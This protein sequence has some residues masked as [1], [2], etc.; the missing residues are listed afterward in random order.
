MAAGA[1]CVG[2]TIRLF[3]DEVSG[4]VYCTQTRSVYYGNKQYLRLLIICLIINTSITEA[5]QSVTGLY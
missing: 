3:S 2:D 5:S 1:L 4:Y